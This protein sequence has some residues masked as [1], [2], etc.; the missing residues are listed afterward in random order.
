[1][2]RVLLYVMLC[3]YL[4]DFICDSS[5][6]VGVRLVF[7]YIRVCICLVGVLVYVRVLY[8]INLLL[9][10]L[11]FVLPMVSIPVRCCENFKEGE[12]VLSLG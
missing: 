12:E 2:G 1:M 9:F 6:V 4:F 11:I 10:G 3:V 5:A 8:G 7:R